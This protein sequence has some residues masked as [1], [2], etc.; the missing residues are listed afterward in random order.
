M[1][2]KKTAAEFD[3][4]VAEN[5]VP[6]SGARNSEVETETAT[7]ANRIDITWFRDVQPNIQTTDLV[8][9]MLGTRAMYVIYGESG[10]GKTFFAT[11]LGLH[12]A[13]GWDWNGRHVEQTGVIYC[14]ME[15]TLGVQN[16][17]AAFKVEYN[18]DRA[19]VPFGYVSVPL[20][21]C[22]S[23][24][25]AVALATHIKAATKPLGLSVGLVF[26]DTLA[27]GM[28][29]GNE[30]A[31]DD[32]GALVRNGD[33][34]REELQAALGWVHHCGKDTAK[35]ARGHSSLRAATDTEIEISINEGAGHVARITKQREYECLGEFAFS[36]KVVELGRNRR[37]K[38]VT[39]C[40][41]DYSS[42][43]APQQPRRNRELT[44]QQ[45]RAF[46]VLTD[47][48]ATSGETGQPGVPDGYSAVP[49][50]WW[51]DQF[52]ERAMPGAEESAKY[53]A[54]KRAAT[55]LVTNGVV[56]MAK[57]HVWVVIQAA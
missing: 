23:D 32:M 57:K 18:L 38:A 25:D 4:K 42:D 47:L 40:V 26:M 8:E 1:R 30:N 9:D 44:G 50:K 35:G 45:K 27:R 3:R 36:L 55:E 29:G 46:Q 37:D 13:L 43:A 54:F 53:K 5:V 2:D 11:D 39:S 7:E 12:I 49:E 34:I 52:F 6:F 15:G 19:D 17:I 41:V 10:S 56:G 24:V 21:L 48:C 16:R 22:G 51:R 33:K 31:P 28:A 20:D 14:A